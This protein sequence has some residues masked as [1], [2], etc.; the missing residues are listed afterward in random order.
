M[1]KILLLLVAACAVIPL[2]ISA[3]VSAHP[4]EGELYVP[5]AE[6]LTGDQ[7]MRSLLGQDQEFQANAAPSAPGTSRCWWRS[8]A[9]AARA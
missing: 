5:W 2:A 9:H 6:E 1:R 3:T 8:N 7:A 4:D